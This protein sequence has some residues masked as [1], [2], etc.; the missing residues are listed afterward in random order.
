MKLGYSTNAFV[1][2]P[3]FDAIDLIAKLGFGGVEIMADR[4]HLSPGLGSRRPHP[5]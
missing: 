1:K 5:A 3:L 4:P 2:Y